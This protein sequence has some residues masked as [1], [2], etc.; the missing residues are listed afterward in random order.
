MLTSPVVWGWFLAACSAPA[1]RAEHVAS[2]VPK[3]AASSKPSLLA[4]AEIVPTPGASGSSTTAAPPIDVAREIAERTV[5][6]TPKAH[7]FLY[8]WTTQKQLEELENGSALLSREMSTTR[9]PSA[10]DDFL[11]AEAARGSDVGKLLFSEG[12]KKKRFAW[13]SP[14]A[15]ITGEA[16][17]S[18]GDVLLEIELR[19]QAWILDY[20]SGSVLGVDGSKGT[21][22]DA[23]K[24]PERIAAVFYLGDGYR[25]FVIVNESMIRRWSAGAAPAVIRA[26]RKDTEFLLAVADAIDDDKTKMPAMPSATEQLLHQ[27]L[28][29][30]RKLGVDELRS[31]AKLIDTLRSMARI[32]VEKEPNVPFVL[33]RQRL[34]LPPIC[35]KV[36]SVSYNSHDV[37]S[38]AAPSRKPVASVLCEPAAPKVVCLANQGKKPADVVCTPLPV[39]SQ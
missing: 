10:F 32:A 23:S 7:R 34:P 30:A 21:L 16:D 35:K 11:S 22:A 25:E 19:D 36:Q 14:F 4:S 12:F 18:Y 17:G 5:G 24:H 39:F 1:E 20:G 27:T 26:L 33:G 8:S 37:G 38:F 2:P 9:G 3:T 13:P 29:F 31:R 28:A 6:G 15:T